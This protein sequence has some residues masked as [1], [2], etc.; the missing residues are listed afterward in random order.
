MK[1]ART[2]P[3]LIGFV[4]IVLLGILVICNPFATLKK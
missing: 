1:K 2:S 4:M 3:L